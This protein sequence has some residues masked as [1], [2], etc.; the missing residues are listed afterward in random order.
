MSPATGFF[1]DSS[2]E[3]KNNFGAVCASKRHVKRNSRFETNKIAQDLL[4]PVIA[5]KRFTTSIRRKV[6]QGAAREFLCRAPRS[7]ETLKNL[8]KILD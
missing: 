4:P 1:T 7:G 6:L 5:V 3:T 8:K 2:A